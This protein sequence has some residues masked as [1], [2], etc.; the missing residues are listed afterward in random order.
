MWKHRTLLS[1]LLLVECSGII[2]LL[3]I[4]SSVERIMVM[5]LC[6]EYK[7]AECGAYGLYFCGNK[8]L[9]ENNKKYHNP[10]T[11]CNG[12]NF[13]VI[14]VQVF[15]SK[16]SGPY[17]HGLE[18]RPDNIF[19]ETNNRI[20]LIF[21]LYK[22]EFGR[23]PDRVIFSSALW[24]CA[25]FEVDDN[26]TSA[27][28]YKEN[29]AWYLDVFSRDINSRI[30]EILA[31]VGSESHVDVGLRTDVWSERRVNSDAWEDAEFLTEVCRMHFPLF[32]KNA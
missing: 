29:V 9:V 22:E 4:G 5:E 10:P 7:N 32:K 25:Y 28:H 17:Y 26:V 24:D 1:L 27:Q 30:N 31:L 2:R 23:L 14:S 6:K 16:Q 3:L 13:H 21:H 15:G 11:M 18:N 19:I 12:T 20:R 8:S